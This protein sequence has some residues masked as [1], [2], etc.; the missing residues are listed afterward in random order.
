[1][2]TALLVLAGYLAGSMPFGYWLPRL[3]EGVDVRRTGSGNI[4]ASNVWRTLGRRYG[5]PVVLLDAAKGFVPVFFATRYL[6]HLEGVLVGM[7]AMLGNWRPLFLRFERGGKAMATGGGAFFALAPL[8]ALTALGIWLAVF[9][10]LGYASVASLCTSGFMPIG[11]WLY[12]Y[13]RPVVAFGVGAALATVFLHRENL[14]RLR[15]GTENR[16]RIAL[17]RRLRPGGH[18]RHDRRGVRSVG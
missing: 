1:V 16:S 2:T 17:V 14:Q 11:A 7:A 9:S 5:I 15:R 6:G 3:L 4:G 10:L 8:A 13:P 12:G 18:G